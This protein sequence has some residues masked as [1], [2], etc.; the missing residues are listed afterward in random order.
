MKD[1]KKKAY[2][3]LEILFIIGFILALI[4]P[5][6]TCEGYGDRSKSYYT[7]EN[8]SSV[9]VM[10]EIFKM[11]N[12]VYPTTNEGLDALIS[13]PNVLKY[14]NYARSLYYEKLP[15][16]GWGIKIVYLKTEDGFELISYGADR[17]EGGEG[18]GAD[19]FYSECK[20]AG[21]NS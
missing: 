9:R 17:K 18:E 20:I 5:K 1:L 21:L 16:D 11:D 15:K 7:C 14:P 19:V 10:L 4:I 8:M 13:N 6:R 12:E 3:F 2:L